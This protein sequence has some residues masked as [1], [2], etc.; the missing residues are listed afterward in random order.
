MIVMKFGGTSVGDAPRLREVVA[1][2]QRALQTT[3]Q[4]V[5]VCSAMAGVTDLLIAAVR[6]AAAGDPAGGWIF[7]P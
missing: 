4:V 5:L 3:D 7:F 6:A 1:L 2:T